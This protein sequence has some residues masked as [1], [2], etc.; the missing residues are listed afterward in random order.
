MSPNSP[1]EV[2]T[3]SSLRGA[4]REIKKLTGVDD[5]FLGVAFRYHHET[6]FPLVKALRATSFV[7]HTDDER[8]ARIRWLA[9]AGPAIDTLK[10]GGVLVVDELDASLHPHLAAALIEMFQDP[11]LNTTGAQL[12]AT[13]HDTSLLGN[14]PTPGLEAAEA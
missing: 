14:T 1:L 8:P 11:D 10:R 2:S 9:T 5:L 6:F 13:T 7:H 3:S 4:N 12:I